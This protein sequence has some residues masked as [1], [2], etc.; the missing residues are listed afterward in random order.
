MEIGTLRDVAAGVAVDGRVNG[1]PHNRSLYC[2]DER[3]ARTEVRNA[4]QATL[5]CFGG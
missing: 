4:A 3:R 2:V 1:P 5:R